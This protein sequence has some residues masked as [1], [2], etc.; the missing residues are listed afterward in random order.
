MQP[1]FQ[2]ILTLTANILPQDFSSGIIAYH[3]NLYMIHKCGLLTE[4]K[5]GDLIPNF[6]FLLFL[7]KIWQI[8]CNCLGD[9]SELEPLIQDLGLPMQYFP[10]CQVGF[11]NA[12]WFV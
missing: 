7:L 5:S 3:Y 10:L 8:F 4:S 11:L 1:I 12:K 2:Q 9:S 6:F